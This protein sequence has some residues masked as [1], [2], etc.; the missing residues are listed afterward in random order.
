[1]QAAV[2]LVSCE[3]TNAAGPWDTSVISGDDAYFC[4]VLLASDGVRFVPEARV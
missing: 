1:M 3:L 4:R 2:R